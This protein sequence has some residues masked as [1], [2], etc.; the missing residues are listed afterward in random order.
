VASSTAGDDGIMYG[1]TGFQHALCGNG[2][3]DVTLPI[4]AN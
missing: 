3:P 1:S 4:I 2:E